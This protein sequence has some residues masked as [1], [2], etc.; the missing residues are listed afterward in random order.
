MPGAGPGNEAGSWEKG[1][2]GCEH[3]EVL[4]LKCPCLSSPQDRPFSWVQKRQKGERTGDGGHPKCTSSLMWSGIGHRWI[5]WERDGFLPVRGCNMFGFSTIFRGDDLL[6]K[7]ARIWQER[8]WGAIAAGDGS[9]ARGQRVG[10]EESHAEGRTTACEAGWGVWRATCKDIGALLEIKHGN[11]KYLS[12]MEVWNVLTR[13]HLKYSSMGNFPASHVWLPEGKFEAEDM[14]EWATCE[15]ASAIW[16]SENQ[17]MQNLYL[18]A[19]GVYTLHLLAWLA[20]VNSQCLIHRISGM[21]TPMDRSYPGSRNIIVQY[22]RHVEPVREK[23]YSASEG[24]GCLYVSVFLRSN[25]VFLKKKH[26]RNLRHRIL[27][28]GSFSK[29]FGWVYKFIPY[30]L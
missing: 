24:K 26:P 28:L 17:D 9:H 19:L 2:P 14:I 5:C 7:V 21:T 25:R 23:P 10:M 6:L 12:K 11:G 20:K 22:A 1:L 27:N 29:V 30:T 15:L 4:V 13:N 3:V 16:S 8:R 18:C